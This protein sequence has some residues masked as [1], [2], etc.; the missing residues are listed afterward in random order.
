MLIRYHLEKLQ[1]TIW[2]FHRLTGLNLR[3]LDVNFSILVSAMDSNPYCDLIHGCSDGSIRC[4]RSDEMLLRLAREKKEPVT[5]ICHAGLCDM[6]VPILNEGVVLGY[7]ILGQISDSARGALDFEK[8]RPLVEDLP[9]DAEELKRAYD[10]LRF[11]DADLITGAAHIVSMLAKHIWLENMIVP[12]SDRT[13]EA[14]CAYVQRHLSEP[15][16][17]TLLCREFGFSHNTLYRLFRERYNCT[18][19]E[20]ITMQR[21][22]CAK[23][24]LEGTELS[25]SVIGEQT[26]IGNEQYF[27]RL[28]RRKTGVTPLQYRKNWRR[29]NPRRE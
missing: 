17:V 18:V 20:Y 5:H 10:S 6:V 4:E 3:I 13:V 19:N 8:I 11:F 16:S 14:L 9:V 25:M 22:E 15:L 28:F 12:E 21:L 23:H 24:L 27:C 1:E 26:G 2:D 29:A 7:I